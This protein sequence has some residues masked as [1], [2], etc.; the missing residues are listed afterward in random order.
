MFPQL[1]ADTPVLQHFIGPNVIP[2]GGD[3]GYA[4]VKCLATYCL[5]DVEVEL[6]CP[7][8]T[9]VG[10]FVKV[11]S[12]GHLGIVSF[13]VAYDLLENPEV[14]SRGRHVFQTGSVY[15]CERGPVIR[16]PVDLAM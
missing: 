14:S 1:I 2:H 15:E 13:K 4:R 5:E 16:D 8:N 9:L 6:G 12:A 7:S 11:Y 3:A 10:D